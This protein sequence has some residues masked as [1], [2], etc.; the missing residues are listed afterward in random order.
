[1]FDTVFTCLQIL[2]GIQALLTEPNLS[3][4][5]QFKAYEVYKGQKAKYKEWVISFWLI[6]A[7]HYVEGIWALLILLMLI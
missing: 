5:A 3:D 1:M 2:E 4:P 7:G 6:S